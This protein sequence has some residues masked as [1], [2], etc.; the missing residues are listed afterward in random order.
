MYCT[1]K[2][3]VSCI[4]LGQIMEEPLVACYL[5]CCAHNASKRDTIHVT[6]VRD[7]GGNRRETHEKV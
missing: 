2:S 1:M 4:E 7:T 5:A 6:A 3:K